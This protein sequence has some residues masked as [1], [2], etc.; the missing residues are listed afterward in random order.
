MN[1]L[2]ATGSSP[3]YYIACKRN[4]RINLNFLRGFINQTELQ[5]CKS[6][7]ASPVDSSPFLSGLPNQQPSMKWGENDGLDLSN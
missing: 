5:T 1:Y 4:L 6:G 2:I 7:T 3:T